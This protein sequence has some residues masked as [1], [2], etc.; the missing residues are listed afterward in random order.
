MICLILMFACYFCCLITLLVVCV[1]ETLVVCGGVYT[2]V[3]LVCLV[4]IDSFRLSLWDMV[5]LVC[6][7]RL[8]AGVLMFTF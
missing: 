3:Y 7:F 1:L 2:G 4:S 5:T 6:L 8:V